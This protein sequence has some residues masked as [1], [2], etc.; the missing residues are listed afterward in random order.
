[1]ER[2]AKPLS[3]AIWLLTAV[4]AAAAVFLVVMNR[5]TLNS[6]PVVFYA[7]LILSSLSFASV[8]SLIARRQPRNPIGWLFSITGLGLAFVPF[9]EEY[10]VRTFAIDPGSLPLGEWIGYADSW[11]TPIALG[12]IPLVFLLFPSGRPRSRAWAI[13]A[14]I[15]VIALGIAFVAG[16]FN[17]VANMGT[18]ERFV[19]NGFRIP[20]PLGVE[21]LGDLLGAV[22]AACAL[23]VIPLS[24]ASAIGLYLRLRKA[25]GEE[26]QQLRWLAYTSAAAVAVFPL[27]LLAF[28]FDDS[29][30][31]GA[32]FWFSI[33]MIICLGI[34]I[35]SGI[36]ILRYRLYDLDI[37]VK[38]T[39]VF[40]VLLTFGALVY[41]AVV[42][43]IGDLLQ[44][45]GNSALT[46]AAAAIVAFAF[47][48]LRA[49]ARRFADR[50][51]YGQRATPYEVLADFADRMTASYSID[52]V[53]PSMAQTIAEA[54]GARRA[55]VW[56]RVG[57]ELRPAASWPDGNGMRAPIGVGDLERIPG[58]D[59][60]FPV[61]HQGD[62]L[63]AL[64]VSMPPSEPLT[65]SQEK[66]L[67]DLASQAGLVLRN[68][69]LVEEVRASRQR[70]V[71]AQD[72][73]AKTLERNLH[74]GAQQQLVALAV[75]L[76][77]AR[78]A[79]EKEGAGSTVELLD[80]LSTDAND[81]LENLRDLARGIYPPLL[82]DKGLGAAI[83]SQARRG[84]VPIEVDASVGRY[85]Q[86]VES[87]AYFCVLEAL[88]NVA[89]YAN[90]THVRIRLFD[91]G[92]ALTFEVADDGA[93]FDAEASSYGTGLQGMAD[94]LDAIAGA[95]EVRSEPGAGTT[96]IGR[97][98]GA[99]SLPDPNEAEQEGRSW[100]S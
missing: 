18:N 31:V 14:W 96:I 60:T 84:T 49:R 79:A 10:A 5:A 86:D 38:K 97:V 75:K 90:A 98:P 17:P 91:D 16:L 71:T 40:G 82:A 11:L 62:L 72:E 67:D 76:R 3:W 21:A 35:A 19:R 22:L 80:G 7:I 9:A 2:I 100:P 8:G 33:T 36:A 56:L 93:G 29:D 73:R 25:H 26:R 34:P 12:G 78:I 43:G 30:L 52:A 47:Q 51:V 70:L 69:R 46:L 99:T 89:K 68:V 61:S 65:P 32:I 6:D 20:N 83:E 39:V 74:D 57:S 53:L 1:M 48:P 55:D 37:V 59:G 66:L 81:A 94:R 77:L 63:G 24:I 88:N 45:R 92:G 4:T 41:L 13:V 87:A 44:R 42:V 15:I 58:G 54:T 28:A 64:T 23:V 95:L 85:P 27:F 50:I